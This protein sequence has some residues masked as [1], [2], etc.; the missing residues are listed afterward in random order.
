MKE[1]NFNNIKKTTFKVTLPDEN[2]TKLTLL[3]PTKS[4][5]AQMKKATS[6]EADESDM[7]ELTAKVISRNKEK[8]RVTVEHLEDC[9]DLEDIIIFFDK[10]M[11][12]VNEM[13]NQKN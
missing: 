4:V 11:D 8:F 1:L 7:F 6:S 2:Q 3:T 5:I 10:Y 12:Y 13:A 9:L